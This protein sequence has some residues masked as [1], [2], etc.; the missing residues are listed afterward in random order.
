MQPWPGPVVSARRL[1]QPQPEPEPETEPQ[2]HQRRSPRRPASRSPTQASPPARCLLVTIALAADDAGGAGGGARGDEEGV[3]DAADAAQRGGSPLPDE[4]IVAEEHLAVYEQAVTELL[5][6]AG[7]ADIVVDVDSRAPDVAIHAR[8]GSGPEAAAALRMLA[9]ERDPLVHTELSTDRQFQLAFEQRAERL[10]AVEA[11]SVRQRSPQQ[12]ATAGGPAARTPGNTRSPPLSDRAPSPRSEWRL[13]GDVDVEQ[14]TVQIADLA[15]EARRLESAPEPQDGDANR[16]AQLRQWIAAAQTVVDQH[17]RNVGSPSPSARLSLSPVTKADRKAAASPSRPKSP[18]QV[19][20]R[21]ETSR[22]GEPV[23]RSG[24]SPGFPAGA[25]VAHM[26]ALEEHRAVESA[27][28]AIERDGALEQVYHALIKHELRHVTH[29]QAP[30]HVG[31]RPQVRAG[32]M[33]CALTSMQLDRGAVASLIDLVSV[34]GEDGEQTV[35]LDQLLDKAYLGYVACLRRRICAGHRGLD[36]E[37]AQHIFSFIDAEGTGGVP[38]W[39]ADEFLG[40]SDD[41]VESSHSVVAQTL[42]VV[43]RCLSRDAVDGQLSVQLEEAFEEVSEK[44]PDPERSKVGRLSRERAT[45]KSPMTDRRVMIDDEQLQAACGWLGLTLSS[46]EAMI[47]IIALDA[48]GSGL[49]SAQQ[50]AERLLST[51]PS[52]PPARRVSV[53]PASLT[54]IWCAEGLEHGSTEAIFERFQ[55]YES[56]H[57]VLTGHECDGEDPFTIIHGKVSGHGAWLSFD[58]R[59]STGQVTVWGA[60]LQ[61]SAEHVVLVDGTWSGEMNGTFFARMEDANGAGSDDDGEGT[62][63]WNSARRSTRPNWRARKRDPDTLDLEAFCMYLADKDPRTLPGAEQLVRQE[64]VAPEAAVQH[65]SES[66]HMSESD[67]ALAQLQEAQEEAAS[68]LLSAQRLRS[69]RASSPEPRIQNGAPVTVSRRRSLSPERERAVVSIER[70][71]SGVGMA[72]NGTQQALFSTP[73][74]R[75][76]GAPGSP[77]DQPGPYAPSPSLRGADLTGRASVSETPIPESFEPRS[78][79]PQMAALENVNPNVD[80]SG[81]WDL[82]SEDERGVTDKM[83]L[84]RAKSLPPANGMLKITVLGCPG[85]DSAT[86]REVAPTIDIWFPTMS[87]SMVTGLWE[88]KSVQLVPAVFGA[89]SRLGKHTS[90][91][92]PSYTSGEGP[93]WCTHTDP[94]REYMVPLMSWLEIVDSVNEGVHSNM[95]SDEA[96]YRFGPADLKRLLEKAYTLKVDIWRCPHGKCKHGRHTPK[97]VHVG[98][99]EINIR[100]V[101]QDDWARE[102]SGT[103]PLLPTE[104]QSATTGTDGVL[105]GDEYLVAKQGWKNS[106]AKL[107][108]MGKNA[109]VMVEPDHLADHAG[110]WDNGQWVTEHL[111]PSG[112]GVVVSVEKDRK[113]TALLNVVALRPGSESGPVQQYPAAHMAPVAYAVRETLEASS[114]HCGYVNEGEMLTELESRVD[115]E[116]VTHIRFEHAP[117]HAPEH[118]PAGSHAAT[119]RGWIACTNPDG[120]E[121]LRKRSAR[122]GHNRWRLP[123][124]AWPT[125]KEVDA[126]VGI[127]GGRFLIDGVDTPARREELLASNPYGAVS[128]KLEYSAGTVVDTSTNPVRI[129]ALPAGPSGG[130]GPRISHAMHFQHAARGLTG[131]SSGVLCHIHGSQGGV[132][133]GSFRVSEMVSGGKELL[134]EQIGDSPVSQNSAASPAS[135]RSPTTSGTP[136]SAPPTP[137]ANCPTEI[138]QRDGNIVIV[139]GQRVQGATPTEG[140]PPSSGADTQAEGVTSH[141]DGWVGSAT[142]PFAAVAMADQPVPADTSK[143]QVVAIRRGLV[144][145]AIDRTRG[146]AQ[147]LHFSCE[148]VAMPMSFD[149]VRKGPESTRIEQTFM[150]GDQKDAASFR[151]SQGLE[152]RLIA[153]KLPRFAWHATVLESHGEGLALC[154]GTQVVRSAI[155]SD[156]SR[157]PLER[158]LR[159]EARQRGVDSFQL[160]LRQATEALSACQAVEVPDDTVTSITN[161][162]WT[163]DG[164]F[165]G[166]QLARQGAPRAEPGFSRSDRHLPA[167]WESAISTT[168]GET[169]YINSATMESTYEFPSEPTKEAVAAVQTSGGATT[170]LDVV[171]EEEGP[172]GVVIG[173]GG[174]IQSVTAGSVA[175]QKMITPRHTIKAI[176][177]VPVLRHHSSAHITAQLKRRPVRMLLE[178]PARTT[179]QTPRSR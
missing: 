86:Y 101:L 123:P 82:T 83:F 162:I 103:R 164:S 130:P 169:Y 20:R 131:L 95:I 138:E 91:S 159:F 157:P 179:Q 30:R 21:V 48:E 11:A 8:F 53:A 147:T 139:V 107:G 62:N 96:D 70:S 39:K 150:L 73:A 115:A 78:S 7:K 42:G 153:Q 90:N 109:R 87:D 172:L 122:A 2:L 145:A 127:R 113:G 65:I 19:V 98:N 40:A 125:P 170:L 43:A 151:Y 29:G 51:S 60:S 152:R 110:H 56:E 24:R 5:A 118:L 85:L 38:I 64:D 37:D 44:S 26:V 141:A 88:T 124:K 100:E 128:L 148:A 97:C 114:A 168:T 167:G 69:G 106:K 12:P 137:T 171:I 135:I 47:L 25:S 16:L 161:D 6:E 34:N 57:G 50:L 140:V 134:L 80:L 94:T 77:Y 174:R 66:V 17:C 79:Q 28:D 10:R 166:G 163:G 68:A 178:R 149:A 89:S 1:P 3:A 52:S 31:A 92:M 55:L 35:Y 144:R 74:A 112:I 160:A 143:R 67:R 105:I 93:T 58:Q 158:A 32:A 36:Q 99:T 84:I 15:A 121:I 59:Y 49:I 72:F 142:I 54:G 61:R 41:L 75:G 71:G 117:E 165:V 13:P 108:R 4:S 111:G 102:W 155:C 23:V 18:Q 45:R 129:L 177:D 22:D 76:E 46:Y 175:A 63:Q 173:E 27:L 9:Q 81:M 104:H 156:G 33:S 14:L 132:A 154:Q 120:S 126:R 146:G 119:L 133:D 136:G 176:A 116:G